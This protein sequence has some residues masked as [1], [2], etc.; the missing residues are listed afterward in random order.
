MCRSHAVR[1]AAARGSGSPSTRRRAAKRSNRRVR[2]PVSTPCMASCEGRLAWAAAGPQAAGPSLRRLHPS[3]VH[4]ITRPSGVCPAGRLLESVRGTPRV[5]TSSCLRTRFFY[6]REALPSSVVGGV[7][8]SSDG[9]VCRLCCRRCRSK[10]AFDC[11]PERRPLG[12]ARFPE[13]TVP[14]DPESHLQIGYEKWTSR[15]RNRVGEARLT[16]AIEPAIRPRALTLRPDTRIP[17]C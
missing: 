6:H 11:T 13:L 2:P 5:S 8:L 3:A 10:R 15:H 7:P 17:I 9:V 16:A 12:G 1:D 14:A 4:R